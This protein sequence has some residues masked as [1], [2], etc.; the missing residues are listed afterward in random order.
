MMQRGRAEG[1]PEN[2]RRCGMRCGRKAT[3]FK[4][5]A[6]GAGLVL[7]LCLPAKALI[8]VLALMLIVCGIV[9]AFR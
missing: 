4:A 7:A 3:G 6:F 2:E 9:L 8:V 5:V 1:A